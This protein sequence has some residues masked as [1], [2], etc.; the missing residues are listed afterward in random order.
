MSDEEKLEAT[1]RSIMGVGA[2]LRAARIARA[3][4]ANLE[5]LDHAKATGLIP[6]DDYDHAKK[7]VLWMMRTIVGECR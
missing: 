2:K 1:R 4:A 5:A 3:A 6:G 7:Y